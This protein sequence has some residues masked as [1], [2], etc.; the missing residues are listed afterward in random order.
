MDKKEYLCKICNKNY[1]SA[2][3]LCNHNKKFH[4]NV[5]KNNDQLL[6]T[7]GQLL[8]TSGQLLSTK[9]KCDVLE[10]KYCN[11][12]FNI[13]QT[14]WKHEQKCKIKDDEKLK[15]ENT[16]LKYE[17][18]LL[19][20]NSNNN[21]QIITTNNNNQ[22]TTTNNKNSNNNNSINNTINIVKFG[23]ERLSEILTDN[24]MLKIT[25]FINSSVNESIKRVHFNNKRPELKNIRIKN[26]KDVYLL[27][28]IEKIINKF[29]IKCLSILFLKHLEIHNG[30]KFITDKKYNNEEIYSKG[31]YF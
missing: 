23:S 18:E 19:K 30:K 24:E 3:S 21:N 20:N 13:R 27:F 15:I 28:F 10:C 17:I 29:K 5:Q 16:K 2:S 14:R 25:E 11:E 1:A 7:S 22:I 26:L 9:N 4:N 8:S 31:I 6:S 12:K